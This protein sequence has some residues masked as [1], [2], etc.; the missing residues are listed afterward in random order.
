MEKVRTKRCRCGRTIELYATAYTIECECGRE[1]N[2]FGQELA[3]RQ[4]WGEETGESLA[5]IM[6]DH[7]PEEV[8]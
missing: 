6:S 7:D 2:T 4:F 3:P 1:F 8:G 5:D